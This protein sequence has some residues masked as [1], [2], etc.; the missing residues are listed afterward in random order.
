MAKK[1][2]STP[3]EKALGEHIG[4]LWIRTFGLLALLFLG[5]WMLLDP[6]PPGHQSVERVSTAFVKD[7]WGVPAGIVFLTLSIPFLVLTGRQIRAL[8]QVAYIRGETSM[9]FFLKG[10]QLTAIQPL[11]DQNDLLVFYPEGQQV[12]VLEDYK[13]QLTEV[14]YKGVE[15]KDFDLNG[16]YWH[17]DE[18]GFML[19]HKGQNLT[20]FDLT[21][22]G[23]DLIAQSQ[24][25]DKTFKLV[26]Y[27][28]SKD[29]K[30]RPAVV[31]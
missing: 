4:Q 6:T 27:K 9:Q 29:L 7:I 20:Q 2:P 17:A 26:D 25:V 11:Y 28:E 13:N 24:E 16:S 3:N 10:I 12:F 23:P 5:S 14:Y 19:I 22:D 1:K 15:S 18:T 31:L 8:G 21:W 30:V